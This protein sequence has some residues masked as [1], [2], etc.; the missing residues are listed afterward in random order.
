MCVRAERAC[1]NVGEPV[2]IE[3]PVC[4]PVQV[5]VFERA[6]QLFISQARLTL[7]EADVGALGEELAQDVDLLNAVCPKDGQ[8]YLV[9]VH[10]PLLAVLFRGELV[11]FMEQPD[12]LP[13]EF[14]FVWRLFNLRQDQAQVAKLCV[15]SHESSKRKEFMPERGAIQSIMAS[16]WLF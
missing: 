7:V 11:G 13:G 3:P 16:L 1:A 9:E 14:V 4:Q 15:E 10:Q 2:F 5:F 12:Q 8:R 6:K